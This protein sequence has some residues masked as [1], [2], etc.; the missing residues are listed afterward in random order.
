MVV[1]LMDVRH[2][3]IPLG[4]SGEYF[5]AELPIPTTLIISRL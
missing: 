1:F 2:Q 5:D 3:K 4:I